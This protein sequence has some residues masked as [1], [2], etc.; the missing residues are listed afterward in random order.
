MFGGRSVSEFSQSFDTGQK[1]EPSAG[2]WRQAPRDVQSVA[3]RAAAPDSGES[4]AVAIALLWLLAFAAAELLLNQPRLMPTLPGTELRLLSLPMALF[5]LA[6]MLRP[7]SEAPM[8]ALTYALSSLWF[9]LKVPHLDFVIARVAIETLQTVALVC[10]TVRYFMHRLGDPLMVGA[11]AVVALL[12]TAVGAGLML[13]AAAV[14]PMSA[15]VYVEQMAGSSSMAWRYWWLGNCCSYMTLG[16]PMA[17]LVTLRHRVKHV[18]AHRGSERRRFVGLTLAVILVSLFAFPIVDMSWLGLPPDVAI[19]RHL[20][21]MPFAM[22]MAARF[23]AYGSAVAVLGFSMIAILSVTGPAASANWGNIVT[24]VTPT[25]TMLLVTASTCMVLAAIS[26]QLKLALNDALEASRLKSRFIAMLNHELRTPLNAILGFSELMRMR[27]LR[28]M[29][30][31][32]GPVENIHASGQRL[33]A[34]IEGLLNQADHGASAFELEKEPVELSRSI[35]LAIDDMCGE[36]AELGVAVSIAARE[37][38][39][40]DADPRALRQMLGVLLTYPLRFVGADTRISVSAEHVA[41]DTILEIGSRGLINATADDRD[42]I[43]VQ[44]VD[45]LALAHGA[46][47]AIIQSDRSS[48]IARLTFFATRAAG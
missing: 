5:A 36:F 13:A 41:T 6:L 45:A 7:A 8:Y 35:A 30:D 25:H 31:A 48:R 44:L 22:A 33:L 12:T 16:A 32:I 27:Q 29:D 4:R 3:Q 9:E 19:A 10:V 14:L 43:E 15:S 47:L 2:A 21:P 20:L 18:L 17:A 23:R 1:L 34:M 46:R 39:W 28:Q 11:W 42:K 37:E 38:L 24:A 26:R 40:I